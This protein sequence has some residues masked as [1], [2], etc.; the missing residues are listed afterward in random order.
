[1]DLE[2]FVPG[3]TLPAKCGFPAAA[4]QMVSPM[5]A[6]VFPDGWT[7]YPLT[8]GG[9]V[10][11]AAIGPSQAV[12]DWAHAQPLRPFPGCGSL[13][14]WAARLSTQIAQYLTSSGRVISGMMIM[15]MLTNGA[16]MSAICDGGESC[17]VLI[18]ASDGPGLCKSCANAERARAMRLN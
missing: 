17:V 8:L 13:V 6:P 2:Q 11:I 15:G 10:M 4:R 3:G 7:N 5:I 14:I 1:M 9:T 16:V 18:P 12:M